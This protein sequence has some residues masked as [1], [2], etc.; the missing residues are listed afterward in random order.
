MTKERLLKE[1]AGMQEAMKQ[2]LFTQVIDNLPYPI[3][4]FE[5]GG[6]LI[7]A[8][9]AMIRNTG[10]LPGDI[11]GRRINFL[12][13]IAIWNEEIFEAAGKVFAGE[14]ALIQD[15][16]ELLVMFSNGKAIPAN[17]DVYHNVVIFPV[18]RDGESVS[19]GV[20]MLMK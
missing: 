7:M 18:F 8:N 19:Y 4:V 6:A 10:L 5:R 16:K 2:G 12:E 1:L 11:E 15:L 20:V 9:Q 17:R 14:T 3:A 13:D